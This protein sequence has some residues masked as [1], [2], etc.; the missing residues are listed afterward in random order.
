MDENLNYHRMYCVKQLELKKSKKV[1]WAGGATAIELK[2]LELASIVHLHKAKT[3]TPR[4]NKPPTT[5]T[6]P[7]RDMSKIGPALWA[8][9]VEELMVLVVVVS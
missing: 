4:P 6:G 7:I 5:A 2:E 8:P 1:R 9:L 3:D